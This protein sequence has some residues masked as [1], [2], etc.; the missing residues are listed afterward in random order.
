[1]V[2]QD[3]TDQFAAVARSLRSE[4]S[5]LETLARAIRVA[6]EVVAGCDYAGITLVRHRSRIE[7][8]AATSD[9]ARRSDQLQLELDEGPC[10]D[11]LRETEAI[12]SPDLVHDRR[13]PLW[14]PRVAHELGVRSIMCFRLFTTKESLGA[15]NL[16]SQRTAAFD[17]RDHATGL[18]FAA[19][20][21]VAVAASRDI[22]GQGQAMVNRTT[23]GQAE[24]M[25]MER[26]SLTP[27]QAF[28]FLKR[29]SQDSNTKLAD[30]AIEFVRS[31]V[32]PGTGSY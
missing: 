25:L 14:A 8:P 11:V 16:Y 28:T 21:A 31:R 13:W 26:Y 24:G 4:P 3:M 18:A 29:I 7:T 19:H 2:L 27:E 20:L 17:V 9:V 30:V 5:E 32:T 23:I 6:V 10:L 22:D 1:M 12:S 15:L